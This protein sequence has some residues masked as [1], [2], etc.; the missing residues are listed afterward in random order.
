MKKSEALKTLGLSEGAT[1]EDIKKAHRKLAIENHPDRFGQDAEARS[2]AEERMKLINE[3]RDVLESGKWEPENASYGSPFVYD[4]FST[5]QATRPG[6]TGSVQN[7][8]D[9][10]PFGNGSF[11]W[12]TYSSDGTTH[13]YTSNVG[14][15][16][17]PYGQANKGSN[18]Q[19][20]F[21]D[22]PFGGPFNS[23]NP[24]A[25]TPFEGSPFES[26]FA[27]K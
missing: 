5:G 3:A 21:Q 6:S 12:T 24:F 18:E 7:P 4:P 25:G 9:D 27:T 1:A 11:V 22:F 10:F 15:N 20:P 26:F 19:N 16:G 2:Q 8:F 23:E 17:H 14:G 13:T